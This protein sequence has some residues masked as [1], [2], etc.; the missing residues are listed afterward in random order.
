MRTRV[1]LKPQVAH[2][3]DPANALVD[4]QGFCAAG[5]TSLRRSIIP[6]PRANLC[7]VPNKVC[8]AAA[9]A[10]MCQGVA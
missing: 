10:L 8:S 5:T 3:A 2:V 4:P 9:C 1:T 6:S 7:L